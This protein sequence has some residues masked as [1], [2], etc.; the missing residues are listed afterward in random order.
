MRSLSGNRIF[1]ALTFVFSFFLAAL[2]LTAHGRMASVQTEF[3]VNEPAPRSVFSP[4]RVVYV[5]E[6]ETKRLRQEKESAVPP[7]YVIDS[8]V[9]GNVSSQAE[10]FFKQLARAAEKKKLDAFRFPWELSQ[11][12]RELLVKPDLREE[13]RKVLALAFGRFFREGILAD[14]AKKELLASGEE[15][16][17]QLDAE[18]KKEAE[19]EPKN[20]LS[21]GEARERVSSFLEEEGIKERKVRGAV[22]EIFGR[23]FQPNL[24]ID[25]EETKERRK[26]AAETVAAV[27]EEIKRGE[28]IVQKGLLI[29]EPQQ[30][31]LA[32]LQKKM[33]ERQVR[34]RLFLVGILVFLALA[35]VFL[36]L[37]EFEPKSLLSRRY[38]T[39]VLVAMLSTL[40]IERITLLVPGSSP[41]LLP[42]ALAAI[43]LTILWNP[44]AGILGSLA[45]PLL[46]V[47]L[48]DFRLDVTLAL[49]AGS[50][51]GAF[52][53]RRTRKRIHFVKIGLATGLVNAAIFFAFFS[54]P[55][56]RWAEAVTVGLLGLANGFM[57]AALAFFLV[58]LFEWL[59]NLTTDITLLELSD[60]NH[61]LLKR[62][63]VE[64][65]GTY[66][67]SLVVST[68]AEGACEA[69]GAN[70][71][72]ARVGCYFHDIGKIARSE[73]F[74]ENQTPQTGDPHKKITATMSCL[75]IMNHVKEGIELARKY[76]LKEVIVRFIPEHQGKGV[77]YYFYKKAL[78]QAAPGEEVRADDFRYPGPKPQSRETAVA[79]LAD[80]VEA[81]SRS[82]REKELTPEG[83]RTLVRKII[84][85]KFI[86]GQLDECDLTLRDLHKIQESFVHNLMAIF[87]TRVRYPTPEPDSQRPDLFK[88]DQ[89][90][91]FR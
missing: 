22:S 74:T 41:H 50:L 82:L 26:A 76:K 84:N 72:L 25:K 54:F 57:V 1:L 6:E 11:E 56:S 77:I 60:L 33:A 12:T 80:S 32:Q 5:N 8:K 37:Y 38:V 34:S 71:L 30:Q 45:V 63:V 2:I 70:A 15:R 19:T 36:Y 51:A 20:I 39:L 49:L 86:D 83:I 29:T 87:H 16:I 79:L 7:V 18:A 3:P 58:P 13:A 24:L 75:V 14:E 89:F 10:T 27:T 28:M 69:V 4:L 21:V 90:T 68:L 44:P 42:G 9:R 65:P 67:H 78:D 47:P 61:P 64:A 40:G 52:A 59:F 73:Y 23:L 66:H 53:A 43:L 85:E 88:A 62:M 17:L 81:S 46:S 31:R 55:E 48:A 35:F 91:K